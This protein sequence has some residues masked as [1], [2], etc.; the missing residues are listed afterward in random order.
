MNIKLKQ[1]LI[2]SIFMICTLLLYQPFKKEDIVTIVNKNLLNPVSTDSDDD[3]SQKINKT[4]VKNNSV[5]ST[6]NHDR[7]E[8]I[9][10]ESAKTSKDALLIIVQLLDKGKDGLAVSLMETLHLRCGFIK[11]WE[12]PYKKTIWAYEKIMNYCEEYDSN[13][14]NEW[15][16]K[17]IQEKIEIIDFSSLVSDNERIDIDELTDEFLR[18][19]SQ[20]EYSSDSIDLRIIETLSYFNQ[21]LGVP[22]RLGQTEE[23][24][25]L[26]IQMVQEIAL[27][28][29]QCERFGGC[30]A[31]EFSSWGICAISNLCQPDWSLINYYQN[32]LSPI[33]Y[34]QVLSIV[35]RLY[36]Y[37]NI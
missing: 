13:L 20:Y 30:G 21:E 29:F 16:G 1:I 26:D 35:A 12:A 8:M 17:Q 10:F 22:L 34:Q 6:I 4:L 15:K 32:T 33:N 18:I 37:G 24:N 14:Y 23:I 27:Q 3:K 5:K 28:I 25:P 19:L 11:G 9:A 36:E 2:L 7:Q 31:D